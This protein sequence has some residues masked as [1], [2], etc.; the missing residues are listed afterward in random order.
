M[1]TARRL[2]P[3]ALLLA[4]ACAAP[5]ATGP[6]PADPAQPSVPDVAAAPI[7]T[8]ITGEDDL[9][10]VDFG[11]QG[12]EATLT[13][14]VNPG[15]ASVL[16][17][18]EAPAED[19][20]V[21]IQRVSA[22]DASVL[23]EADFAT[24]EVLVGDAHPGV[25]ADTGGIA[26]LLPSRPEQPL[27]QGTYIV[28][29]VGND[30]I[31]TA[32]AIVRSGDVD[33]PQA[34]DLALWVTADLSDQARAAVAPAVVAATEP[35]LAPHGLRLGM[36]EVV[37][38]DAAARERF[39]ALELA[40]AAAELH[41][42]CEEAVATV[43]MGR[44]AIVVLV[45][46]L[47]AAGADAASSAGRV[48]GFAAAAPGSVLRGAA[49]R[50]CAAVALDGGAVTPEVARTVVHEAA[51]LLGLTGHTSEP[52]GRTFDRFADTPECT[53]SDHDVDGDGVVDREECAAADGGYLMFWG[54]G[55]DQLSADQAWTLRRHPVLRAA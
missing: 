24:S 43:G 18:L 36:V 22:P 6:G 32:Q 48:A 34:A 30:G 47:A 20:V 52:D 4:L 27:Q 10:L 29:V 7:T 12:A 28:D 40:N 15:D 2:A 49:S 46:R 31:G 41:A 5:V 54:D 8:A 14:E 55:G 13:V 53:I 19:Q 33:G 3:A 23:Y 39:G 35:A 25:L 26:L 50:A 51:H 9:R 44:H 21:G 45:D 38:A 16:L 1:A 11:R 17:L 42:V 37:Q